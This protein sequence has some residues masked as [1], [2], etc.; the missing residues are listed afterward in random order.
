VELQKKVTKKIT[1]AANEQLTDI[2]HALGLGNIQIGGAPGVP[3]GGTIDPSQPI[4]GV[5]EEVSPPVDTAAA[6]TESGIENPHEAGMDESVPPPANTAPGVIA[7]GE[8]EIDVSGVEGS[9]PLATAQ[10]QA[11]TEDTNVPQLDNA[12]NDESES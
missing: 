11:S 6:A 4:P 12:Y 3:G 7:G 5:P 9:G 1:D 8:E 10:Q 2:N